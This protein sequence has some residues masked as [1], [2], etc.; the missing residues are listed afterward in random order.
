MPDSIAP[1]TITIEEREKN[2]INS[3]VQKLDTLKIEVPDSFVLLSFE[4]LENRLSEEEKSLMR[5]ILN[6]EP[7]KYGVKAPYLGIE[8]VP[9]DIVAIKGQKYIWEGE[10]KNIATQ[11]LPKNVYDAYLEMNK[12]LKKDISS[13]TVAGSDPA[14]VG[15]LVKSGYRSPAYQFLTFIHWLQKNDF[16]IQKTFARVALP[17][18]SEHGYPPRQA[19]DFMNTA[20]V[21]WGNKICFDETE[22]YKWL[23]KNAAAYGFFLSYPKD[24]DEGMMFEPW[25]W[26]YS[27]KR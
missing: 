16:D 23:L 19:I 18:Y 12:A 21:I 24:N 6:I 10:E 8:S 5:T 22:E 26:H 2:I 25:H 11:Y 27:A 20:G 15:L 4:E 1:V 13:T 9:Q 7:T 3:L 17:G 14:T